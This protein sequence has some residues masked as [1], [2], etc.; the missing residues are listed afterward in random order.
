LERFEKKK[1]LRYEP[2]PKL[3]DYT[4]K[5]MVFGQVLAVFQVL[6]LQNRGIYGRFPKN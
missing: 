5:R 4:L 6:A 3:I 2:V 1:T